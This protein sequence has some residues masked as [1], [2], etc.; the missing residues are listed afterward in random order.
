MARP[1]KNGLDYFPVDV[2]FEND[3]KI[4]LI[5]VLHGNEGSMIFFKLLSRVYKNGYFYKW[6]EKEQ[7]LFSKR[8][9]VD[10]NK[11]N[12][13]INDTIKYE[14][15]NSDLFETYNILTSERIQRTYIEA[16]GRRKNIKMN[17]DFLL[18]DINEHK[19]GVNVDIILINDNEKP[20]KKN[21][22][23]RKETEIKVNGNETL[24]NDI[25]IDLLN[26]IMEYF[27]F[28]EMRNPDKQKH[29]FHFLKILKTDNQT[30]YFREQFEAYRKFKAESKQIKHS[31]QNFLGTIEERYL[32]GGWNARN[33]QKELTE[34]KSNTENKEVNTVIMNAI[35]RMI[36]DK[37]W[38]DSVYEQFKN[39]LTRDQLKE[40]FREFSEK[41]KYSSLVKTDNTLKNEFIE[42]LQS[43]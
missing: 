35:N 1:I 5:E 17:A 13:I 2:D 34:T 25:D 38:A 19:N 9:N 37:K 12:A 41:Q 30:E 16:T 36:Q 42:E 43:T 18:I 27:G 29:L 10:I 20:P 15:F 33:W 8:V 11:V 21:K 22:I 23:N 39:H 40:R 24:L 26:S 4:Q 31:F 6:T 14:L 3:D 28:T 32:D 7:L